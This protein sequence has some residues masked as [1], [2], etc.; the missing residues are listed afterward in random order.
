MR[1]TGVLAEM[2]TTVDS[3]VSAQSTK[4]L[5]VPCSCSS[6]VY[7]SPVTRFRMRPRGVVSTK[8]SGTRMRVETSFSCR[9]RLAAR[10]RVAR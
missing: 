8:E 9:E 10:D 1:K 6:T 5:M 4:L 7:M 2:T 3:T